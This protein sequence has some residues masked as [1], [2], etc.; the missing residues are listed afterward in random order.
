MLLKQY[1]YSKLNSF[2]S[3]QA[4]GKEDKTTGSRRQIKHIG[5]PG[6]ALTA[7]M[8]YITAYITW[9]MSALMFRQRVLAKKCGQGDL[10]EHVSTNVSTAGAGKEVRTRQSPEPAGAYRDAC[11]HKA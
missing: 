4:D 5:R 11:L 7:V 10:V 9:S 8:A 3:G 1:V 6:I 2:L